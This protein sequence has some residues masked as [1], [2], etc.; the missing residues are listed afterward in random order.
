MT[1]Q[2]GRTPRLFAPIDLGSKRSPAAVR[3]HIVPKLRIIAGSTQVIQHRA[4]V[5]L[6]LVPS[7]IPE[8]SDCRPIGV[9]ADIALAGSPDFPA[10]DA[11]NL[12]SSTPQI[13]DGGLRNVRRWQA[14]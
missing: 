12:A 6:R 8:G 14:H 7:G 10:R 2:G 4:S 3:F 11:K 5:D 9:D 13:V 1:A